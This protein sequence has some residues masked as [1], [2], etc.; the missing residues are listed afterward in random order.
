MTDYPDATNV[1]TPPNTNF[2]R[3]VTGDF[4][5]ASDGEVI[6]ATK[7]TG[8][9]YVENDNVTIYDSR[10]FTEVKILGPDTS[11]LRIWDT[12]IG[13]AT[14]VRAGQGIGPR[15]FTARRIEIFGTFDGVKAQGNVDVRD[16][17]IHDLY[18]TTDLSQP[19]GMTHNDCVQIQAGGD[20][21]FEH[22]TI[23]CWSFGDGQQAGTYEL[24]SPYS[25]EGYTT[26][27]FLIS[28]CCGDI[29]GVTI[30]ANQIRGATSKHVI[31]TDT[32]STS[33]VSI[34]NNYIGPDD[35]DWPKWHSIYLGTNPQI[36]NNTS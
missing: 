30:N 16:S 5:T 27:A 10:I 21:I 29:T 3:T 19:N 22:N 17:Y 33:N 9:L 26:S 36:S 4:H 11:G 8:T 7:V 28:A 32:G 34:T 1:G 20:N 31:V 15:N 18:R 25:G 2:T 12:T 35:R 23:H 14:G 13:T 24:L 6:N